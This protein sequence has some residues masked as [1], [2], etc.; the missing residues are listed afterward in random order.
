MT[1]AS[2]Y[3][4]RA[5]MPVSSLTN[6][7]QYVT[8]TTVFHAGY[9]S[10]LRNYRESGKIISR[11]SILRSPSPIPLHSSNSS[12]N[13]STELLE[14]KV[15]IHNEGD[16]LLSLEEK[17]KTNSRVI[18]NDDNLRCNRDTR[19]NFKHDLSRYRNGQFD[20]NQLQRTSNF[21]SHLRSLSGSDGASG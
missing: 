3:Y 16:E 1:T 2:T 8:P 4:R 5:S 18:G 12:I 15:P 21:S 13:R 9:S 20:Q 11:Y 17:V 7:H 14:K 10:N 19:A 6:R